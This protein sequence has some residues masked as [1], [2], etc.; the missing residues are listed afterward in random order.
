MRSWMNAWAAWSGAPRGDD[1]RIF[2]KWRDAPWS[3]GWRA[4]GG[5]GERGDLVGDRQAC[6]WRV[7]CPEDAARSMVRMITVLTTGA[8]T[9]Q[10]VAL[11]RSIVNNEDGQP[12]TVS[13]ARKR[14]WR[15]NYLGC[16]MG[17]DFEITTP[18]SSVQW[19]D[20]NGRVATSQLGWCRAV[21]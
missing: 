7:W 11:V 13:R 15:C 12:A 3:R 16:R 2:L 5:N 6:L 18:E 8:M 10:W 4:D 20:D 9:G 14:K 21:R 1:A 19:E 17:Q